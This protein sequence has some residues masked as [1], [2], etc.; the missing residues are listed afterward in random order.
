MLVESFATVRPTWLDPRVRV[1]K[2]RRPDGMLTYLRSALVFY[3]HGLYL[4]PK[5]PSNQVIVNVWH[6]MPIKAIG[7]DIGQENPPQFSV[8]L[9]TSERFAGIVSRSFGIDVGDVWV[10]GLPRNDLLLNASDV[11]PFS[12]RFTVWLP[13]YRR[14]VVGER[15]NE[16]NVQLGLPNLEFLQALVNTLHAVE[17]QLVVKLH[18]M[19]DPTEGDIFRKAGVEVLDDLWFADHNTTLYGLL[20]SSSALISDYSSVAIDYLVTSKPMV[21]VQ[22]DRYDYDA[23]R[24][25]NF[26]PEELSQIAAVVESYDEF[27][28]YS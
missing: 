2:V 15:R 12:S 7:R 28:R 18:P 3:T 17:Q 25:L 6:G 1:R 4:S 11:N 16:G 8:T 22:Q 23:T 21:L 26:D 9:A 27:R 20:S 19:A 24:G 13:T 10:T 5:P 14:S